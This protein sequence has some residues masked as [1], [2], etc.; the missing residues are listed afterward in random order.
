MKKYILSLMALLLTATALVSCGDDFDD[1][2]VNYPQGFPTS[3]VW[4][5]EFTNNDDCEYTVIYNMQE[6]FPTLTVLMYGKE[7]DEG[8]T[9]YF[10][11]CFMGDEIEYDAEIGQM[12]VNGVSSW[13]TARVYLS[14]L[15][16]LKTLS[17]HLEVYDA[18]YD[19]WS[20][21]C[22]SSL[23]PVA[24]QPLHGYMLDGTGAVN[25]E[26]ESDGLFYR[27]ILGYPDWGVAYGYFGA[28]SSRRADLRN[29]EIIDFHYSMSGN[30]YNLVSTEGEQM[31]LGVNENYEPI[32]NFR[33]KVLTLDLKDNQISRELFI[34]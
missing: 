8:A 12:I 1:I 28:K 14:Y 5:S 4:S 9:G 21:Y 3:G 7:Y 18:R 26:G 25:A 22:L 23:K 32:L 24:S 30:A 31:S 27:L 15:N 20:V 10:T 34:D 11:T 2:K 33:G 29:A 13:G 19:E 16:D 17:M 6:G